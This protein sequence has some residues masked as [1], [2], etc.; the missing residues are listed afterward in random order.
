MTTAPAGTTNPLLDMADIL[1]A[2]RGRLE[3]IGL[4]MGVCDAQGDCARAYVPADD[5][6]RCLEDGSDD[7]LPARLAAARAALESGQTATAAGPAGGALI[8]VPIFRR[9]RLLGAIVTGYPT[10]EALDD[11]T[12]TAAL[13]ACNAG[14][15]LL[16]RAPTIVRHSRAQANDFARVVEW[17][18]QQ[19]QAAAVGREEIDHLSRNLGGTYEELSLVYRLSGQMKVTQ[20]PR[21]FFRGLCGEVREVINMSAAAVVLYPREGR[22]ELDLVVL[23]GSVDLNAPQ[24]RLLAA[25]QLA[26]RLEGNRPVVDNRFAPAGGCGIA[27]G[28]IANLIAA[29]LVTDKSAMGMLI[30]MNKGDGDFDS[31]DLKLLNSIAN[32]ASIY[33]ANNRLYGELEELMLGALHALTASIDAKDPYTCGHSRRVALISRRIAQEIGLSDAEVQRIYLSGL[34]HDVGKIGVP[35]GVLC[36]PGRLT[37]EEYDSMKRHPGI[38]ANILSGI[39]ALE[40]VLPGIFTHHERPDGRGYPQGLAGDAFPLQGRIV[41]LADGFDAMTSNRTYRK[42]LSLE[43]VV[44]E[45]RRCAGAQFDPHL[46]EV[47]L[48]LDLERL[49]ED[50]RSPEQAGGTVPQESAA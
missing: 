41:G 20:S 24:V 11:G 19:E 8:A 10:R 40:D 3:Q 42:A 28:A 38:G 48:A 43:T 27:A 22:D 9:R 44:A 2:L 50:L 15:D 21:E 13:R 25:T 4:G 39:R 46:V 32:Q 12:L 34:L 30:G 33:L 31:P 49:L 16:A 29:P 17:L 5:V 1:A 36:K 23:D 18:L 35:E 26:E 37:D 6:C 45:I 14:D 47:F 7:C